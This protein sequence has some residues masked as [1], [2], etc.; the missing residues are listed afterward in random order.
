[1]NWAPKEVLADFVT[2]ARLAKVA[3]TA[4]DI[5]V[6][7]LPAPHSPPTRLPAGQMAVYVFSLGGDVLK[8]GK[9]GPKS[10][11]RYT[12]QHYNPGSAQSTLAAS[13]IGDAERLGLADAECA[14]IGNWIRAN[15]DRVNILIPVDHGVAVLTLLESFL[16]CSLRPRYEGFRSQRE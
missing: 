16:Q 13:I 3:L 5:G 15:V 14:K 12:S 11:A 7:E 6:E 9:V 1:M 8:V 10:Q 4:G 2:V